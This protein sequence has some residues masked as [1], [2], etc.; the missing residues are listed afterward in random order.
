MAETLRYAVESAEERGWEAY[1]D[2][3]KVSDCPFQAEGLKL[4]WCAG[5][6]RAQLSIF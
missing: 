2:G 6:R 4:A 5:F 3:L 1:R